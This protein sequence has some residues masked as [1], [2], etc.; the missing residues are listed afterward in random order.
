MAGIQLTGL[1]SGM[2]W[3]TT[4]TQLMQIER[5]PQDNLRKQ[6]AAAQKLQSAY[7]TL[8]TNLL[9]LKT[10][11]SALTTS[12]SGA[13]RAAQIVSATDSLTG[14]GGNVLLLRGGRG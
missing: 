8:K 6:Q 7:D 11:A 12:A 4:V 2:D 13:P 10:A 9:T 1:A 3:K 14:A 5:I